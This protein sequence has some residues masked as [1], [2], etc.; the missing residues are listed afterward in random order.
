MCALPPPGSEVGFAQLSFP[1]SLLVILTW[2]FYSSFSKFSVKWIASLTEPAVQHWL[3]WLASCKDLPSPFP[4]PPPLAHTHTHT[5]THTHSHSH[6]HT[7]TL[8]HTHTHTHSLTHTQ[9]ARTRDMH[10]L[11]QLFA[12]LW[13]FQSSVFMLVWHLTYWD[14]LSGPGTIKD[15]KTRF[16]NSNQC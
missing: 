12:W 11:A 14:I 7:H 15:W 16:W 1:L 2:C 8:T 5:H 4:D 9:I 13:E 10:N 3:G 6:T